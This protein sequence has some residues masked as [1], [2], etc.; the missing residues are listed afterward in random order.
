VKLEEIEQKAYDAIDQD[1]FARAHKLLS[2]I[3]DERSP[4]ALLALGWMHDNGLAVTEN[5]EVAQ[6]YY[7]RAIDAG[8]LVAYHRLGMLYLEKE[9]EDSA[10]ET[11]RTGAEQG[12][13]LCMYEIGIMLLD[14]KGENANEQGAKDWFN[15]AADLGHFWSKRKLL[16]IE[17]KQ[18]KWIIHK[19]L[20]NIRIVF[21]GIKAGLIYFNDPRSERIQ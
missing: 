8:S 18:A 14:G 9:N 1:D 3:A 12:N 19:V 10:R 7:I 15:R 6:S 11:F 16:E 5:K 17:N 4:Y 21:F 2:Q 20:I 13:L